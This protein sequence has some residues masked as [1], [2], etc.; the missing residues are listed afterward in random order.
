MSASRPVLASIDKQSYASDL[1]DR[2]GCG[3]ACGADD[4]NALEKG[5]IELYENRN[6]RKEM[7]A[8]GR[9]YVTK[10]LNK[11]IATKKYVDVIK[12]VIEK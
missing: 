11:D 4:V 12:S 6:R 2:I 10:E 3:V 1:I 7:G 5:L 8:K 9:D